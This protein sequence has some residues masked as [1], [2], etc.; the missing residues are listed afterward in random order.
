MDDA[1]TAI[2][3][4]LSI[5]LGAISLAIGGFLIYPAI[6]RIARGRLLLSSRQKAKRRNSSNRQA[7]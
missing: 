7:Y 6:Y 3:I 1:L 5:F 2:N 4:F